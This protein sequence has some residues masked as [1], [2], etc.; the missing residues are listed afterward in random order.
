MKR[1]VIHIFALISA[2]S[3]GGVAHAESGYRTGHHEFIAQSAGTNS[4][5]MTKSRV[6]HNGAFSDGRVTPDNVD[7]HPR[8][9]QSSNIMMGSDMGSRDSLPPGAGNNR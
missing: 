3:A 6:T 9:S 7:I 2:I 1:N 8:S 5:V 4:G